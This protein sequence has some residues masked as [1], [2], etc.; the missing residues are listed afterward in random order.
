VKQRD[1]VPS[2]YTVI[3][4]P[5]SAWRTKFGIT[6]PY[7]PVWRGPTVLKRRATTVGSFFS[8]Q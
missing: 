2:P 3:G 7:M 1:W 5:A 6:M 4:W 8:F